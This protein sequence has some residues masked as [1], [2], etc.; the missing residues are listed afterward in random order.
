MDTDSD[1]GK[2]AFA[3]VIILCGVAYVVYHNRL[4]IRK[5]VRQCLKKKS[6]ETPVLANAAMM[7]VCNAFIA[8]AS[9]FQGVFE[10]MF[11][12]SQ[13]IISKERKYNTLAEWNIRMKNINKAPACLKGWWATVV[14]GKETLS[15]EELRVRASMVMKMLITAGIVRD[16]RKTLEVM[17]DTS[18]YYQSYDNVS[19]NVGQEL[20]I[21]SPCW[22][23]PCS[24]VRILEKGYCEII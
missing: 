8:Y 14:A 15:D 19:W 12:A 2:K 22:Y 10:P 1:A 5:F 7:D 4:K 11:K 18:L 9:N 17:A 23:L 20:R 16:D 21:E 3:L 13:G 6:Q 24:P